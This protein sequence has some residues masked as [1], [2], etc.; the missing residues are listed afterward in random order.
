ML[1][2]TEKAR[3]ALIARRD[4]LETMSS[5]SAGSR[6]TVPLDQQSMGRLSRMDAIQQQAMAQATERQRAL[7]LVKIETALQRIEEDDYGY[8]LACGEEI[9][10]K[11]LEVD[12]TASHCVQCAK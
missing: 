3:A 1:M 11:R 12:P 4:E 10:T 5:I 7:E 6:V 9:S 2:N 8:C